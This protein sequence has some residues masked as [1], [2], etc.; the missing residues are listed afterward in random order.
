MKNNAENISSNLIYIFGFLCCSAIT[1]KFIFVSIAVFK[2]LIFLFP[3]P[4]F[5]VVISTHY[6]LH[7]MYLC[8]GFYCVESINFLSLEYF[9]MLAFLGF[10]LFCFVLFFA[11][12]CFPFG[13]KWILQDLLFLAHIYFIIYFEK[14]D[15]FISLWLGGYC[16]YLWVSVYLNQREE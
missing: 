2:I 14:R 13:R 7:L 12:F 1:E 6:F 11:C 4:F 3:S 16:Q 8:I 15:I 5:Y 9:A 10:F